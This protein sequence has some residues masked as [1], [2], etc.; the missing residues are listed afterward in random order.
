MYKYYII[1]N[2]GNKKEMYGVIKET[3][4]YI[5]VEILKP[6]SK[7]KAKTKTLVLDKATI[8]KNIG[9]FDFTTSIEQ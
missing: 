3:Q 4:K 7:L 1:R 5:T 9:Q 2:I 6:K 8:T